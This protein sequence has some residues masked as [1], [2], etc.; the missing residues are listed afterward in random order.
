MNR[1][2]VHLAVVI[3]LASW[4]VL[5]ATDASAQMFWDAEK[6]AASPPRRRQLNCRKAVAYWRAYDIV[7]SGNP[8]AEPTD[9]PSPIAF[10]YAKIIQHARPESLNSYHV[11]KLCE[12]SQPLAQNVGKG[13]LDHPVSADK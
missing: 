2:E 13:L 11:L 6:V 4:V 9:V 3:L 7:P 8:S 5:Q 1:L 12:R 10:H